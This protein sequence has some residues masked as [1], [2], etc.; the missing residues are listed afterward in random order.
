MAAF[1]RSEAFWVINFLEI[2]NSSEKLQQ[3]Y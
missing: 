2:E 1:G 3:W